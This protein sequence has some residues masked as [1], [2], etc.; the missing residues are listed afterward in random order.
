MVEAFCEAAYTLIMNTSPAG[1]D[2]IKSYLQD[3]PNL[4]GVY[5]M[6]DAEGN[7]LYVG[8]AKNLRNRVANY[9]TL[10]D[11]N[12]R[13]MTM[14]NQT[15]A[16]EFI[17]TKNESEALL[18]EANLIKKLQPR[19]N[20]L[21][22][23]DK[24][25]PYLLLTHH[26]FPQIRIYRGAKTIKGDYFG[27][28]AS[29]GDLY[30]TIQHLQR[31]LLL[32]PC[33]DNYFESRKRPCLQ[34]QIKRCSAP[35]V[36]LISQ[37]DYA[38]LVGEA[39]KLL[40]GQSRAVQ[41]AVLAEMQEAAEKEEYE[42]AAILR[43]RLKA[44]TKIQQEQGLQVP[45]IDEADVV[46]LVRDKTLACVQVFLYRNGQNFGNLPYFLNCHEEQSEAELM[47]AFLAQFYQRHDAPK[48]LLLSHEPED[49][50][51]LAGALKEKC[52]HAVSFAVPQRGEKAEVIAQAL[53]NAKMALQRKLDE[54]M[55][56]AH[57][58]EGVAK[59]FN[60]PAPPK[61]IEV[62]DNSHIS[63]TDAI[64]GMIVASPEG[65][66]K[67]AYRKFNIK[68]ASGDDDYGMMRE[69][70]S[71]RLQ[72]LSAPCSVPRE[73]ISEHGTQNTEH[74]PDLLLI[75][76]G[77]GQ[78]S[79]ALDVLQELSLNIPIV[80]IAKG[81]D[82]NAGRERFFLPLPLSNTTPLPPA[83]GVG[84]GRQSSSE[85][86]DS[87]LL[88]PHPS[89]PPQAV[90]G[91]KSY[92]E[93]QLPINDPVLHYLQRLRDEAHR[94]AIGTH[95]DK[96]SAK[97]K[98]SELDSISGIAAKRK[99]ALLHY[100]GSSRAVANATVEELSKVEGISQK[101]AQMIWNHFHE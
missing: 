36:N 14:I 4:P 2:L 10:R 52:G 28:F 69:V 75:D 22:R 94:F 6:L 42:R 31:A 70:L 18:L 58:L 81:P 23:D 78:L 56:E 26:E 55:G 43:D 101:T 15:C 82:R 61:R 80:A 98:R 35:C 13:L 59:I 95:R 87:N 7:P 73:E 44:L 76:G 25:F 64:G 79:A 85:H 53:K 49:A 32:R 77:A 46:V 45:S 86:P 1:T 60:L 72:R 91:A 34:Y 37:A 71:R 11:K 24:S 54:R 48:Q 57:L 19:Y 51:W 90:E 16:M 62:Y 96:R 89:P 97:I 12:M 20:I 92:K 65:L 63:G 67:K 99:K 29:K 74:A 30:H 17:T 68:T 50:E 93:F 39:K 27:P 8:K 88:H 83:G 41:E 9:T 5:R 84:G 3:L 40:R 21:L 33:T 38:K 47:A 66:M 100:F